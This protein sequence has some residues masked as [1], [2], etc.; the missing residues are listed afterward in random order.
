MTL[1]L[2]IAYRAKEVYLQPTA[3]ANPV[4]NY[5]EFL[6]LNNFNPLRIYFTKIKL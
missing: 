1:N 2:S 5:S 3:I 6:F 4:L